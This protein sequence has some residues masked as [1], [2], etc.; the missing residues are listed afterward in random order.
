VL[1]WL[2]K[3]FP[4]LPE[5]CPLCGN[6]MVHWTDWAIEDGYR[7]ERLWFGCTTYTDMTAEN[8]FKRFEHY[9]HWTPGKRI[10]TYDRYTGE[11]IDER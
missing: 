10:P 8:R 4:P 2:R 9:A 6:V 7:Q 5:Y 3:K 1:N 11:K